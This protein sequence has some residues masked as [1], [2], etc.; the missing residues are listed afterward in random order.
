MAVRFIGGRTRRKY[1][2]EHRTQ[3]LLLP[4]IKVNWYVLAKQGT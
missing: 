4:A 1:K 3:M 2:K